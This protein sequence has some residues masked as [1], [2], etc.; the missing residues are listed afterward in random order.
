VP[1][2]PPG[3]TAVDPRLWTRV[4]ARVLAD[5]PVKE[6]GFSLLTWAGY[7]DGAN[8]RPGYPLLMRVTGIGSK[9]TVSTALGQ[10]RDFGFIWKYREGNARRKESDEYRLTFPDDISAIPMM[11][12]EWHLPES[13]TCGQPSDQ[14][15]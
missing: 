2:P 7:A 13:C 6:V 3:L 9:T 15:Q 4:W 1:D 10:I 11:C 5:R 12:P 8:I 14:V